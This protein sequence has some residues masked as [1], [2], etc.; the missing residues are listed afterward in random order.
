[1][2]FTKARTPTHSQLSNH[3]KSM[4]WVGG[5]L[6]LEILMWQTKEKNYLP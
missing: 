4:E 1:M 2:N 6:G 5:D 3:T